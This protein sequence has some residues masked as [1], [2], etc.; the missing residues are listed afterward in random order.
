MVLLLLSCGRAADDRQETTTSSPPAGSTS[1]VTLGALAFDLA[2]DAT[3]AIHDDANGTGIDLLGDGASNFTRTKTCTASGG[4]AVVDI[5]FSGTSDRTVKRARISASLTIT[6]MGK[7]TR[8]WIPPANLALACTASGTSAKI[9]WQDQ[10]LT[11]GLVTQISV[12]KT[13][14]FS[15]SVTTP[16]KSFRTSNSVSIKGTRTV[17]WSGATDGSAAVRDKKIVVAVTRNGSRV[18]QDGSKSAVQTAVTTLADA[19]LTVSVERNPGDAG[20]DRTLK[21]K[22]IKSGTLSSTQVDGTV[23]QTTFDSVVYDFSSTNDDKCQP[24][25]GK[26]IGKVFAPGVTVAAKTFVIT[27]GDT[28]VDSGTSIAFDGGTAEDYPDY[29][30][31]GCD[32]E[33]ET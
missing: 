7:E 29:N 8:T 22:T 14:A 4:R 1:K 31:K 3:D 32:L 18:E 21:K 26:M 30:A 15:R 12:D 6:A 19:P 25:S 17:T 5:T 2:D 23:I 10:A 27:F 24:L 33:S 20:G 11:D 28:T 9:N 16:K 13:R